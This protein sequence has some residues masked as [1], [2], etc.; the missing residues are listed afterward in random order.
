[1]LAEVGV[2][3][4]GLTLEESA[5]ELSWVVSRIHF[6]PPWNEGL[7]FL[8]AISQLESLARNSAINPWCMGSPNM[9]T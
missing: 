1:M 6:F 9:V 8:L 5:P 2:S 3:Y 7:I 4:E